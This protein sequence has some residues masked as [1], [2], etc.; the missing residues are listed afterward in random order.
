MGFSVCVIG[1]DKGIM[2][3]DGEVSYLVGLCMWKN[4]GYSVVMG[5]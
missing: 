3:G 4:G 1:R 5:K 2:V